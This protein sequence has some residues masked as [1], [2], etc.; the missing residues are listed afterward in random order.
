MTKTNWYVVYTR[1]RYELRVAQL[2]TRKHIKNY[3]PLHVV[4][5]AFFDAKKVVL[6]PLF[7]SY[8]FVCIQEH[9]LNIVL[10]TPGVINYLYWLNKPAT[11]AD[12]E[13]GSLV[14]LLREHNSVIPKKCEIRL[15]SALKDEDYQCIVPEMPS[16]SKQ[17]RLVLPSLGYCLV[18]NTN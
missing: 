3:C 4:E 1:P 7:H 10:N 6:E 14:Q 17:V 11:I 2:L 8:V 12:D 5:N 16:E 15:N 9:E 18:V 13:I